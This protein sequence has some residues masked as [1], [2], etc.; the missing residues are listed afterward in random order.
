MTKQPSD[1]EIEF[2]RNLAIGINQTAEQL[3]AKRDIDNL[4]IIGAAAK[5]LAEKRG[6]TSVAN[7]LRDLADALERGDPSLDV[8]PNLPG[9]S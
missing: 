5:V 4:V 1:A 6:G 9:K 7:D 2:Q 8:A 3:R